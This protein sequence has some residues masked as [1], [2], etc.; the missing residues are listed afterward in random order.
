MH[1]L[2]GQLEQLDE[3]HDV[4]NSSLEDSESEDDDDDGQL[5]DNGLLL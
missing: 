1:A 3:A 5:N 4:D 2:L